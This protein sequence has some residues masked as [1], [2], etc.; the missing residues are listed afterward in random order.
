MTGLTSVALNCTLKTSAA[1]PS[2]TDMLLN[3]VLDA[4]SQQGVTSSAPIRIA[5]YN[6]AP[7][8]SSDEGAGDQWPEIR[9][10]ILSADIF[11]LGTPIWMGHPSSIAQRVLER[12]DAFLGETDELGRMISLDRVAIVAVVGN[13]DGAHHVGAEL[14]QG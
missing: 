4:L 5:D 9:E 3:E 2:S 1:G 8:V 11:V 7:G 12:L 10:R 13:E 6:V 14:V